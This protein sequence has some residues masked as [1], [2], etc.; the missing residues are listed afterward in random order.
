MLHWLRRQTLPIGP[1]LFRVSICN[2][3][4]NV[5]GFKKQQLS[6]LWSQVE[7]E[8]VSSLCHGKTTEPVQASGL[9]SRPLPNPCPRLSAIQAGL[10]AQ[11]PH[12]GK[13]WFEPKIQSI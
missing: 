3:R 12:L 13:G 5:S 7:E 4:R 9:H 10:A 8:A 6:A 11:L 2:Q 1:S